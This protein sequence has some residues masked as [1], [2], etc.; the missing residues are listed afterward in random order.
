MLI[1]QDSRQ[2]KVY[3]EVFISKVRLGLAISRF[4]QFY[5]QRTISDPSSTGAINARHKP[6]RWSI[7]LG[8]ARLNWAFFEL[9]KLSRNFLDKLSSLNYKNSLFGSGNALY[10]LSFNPSSAQIIHLGWSKSGGLAMST[11]S[12]LQDLVF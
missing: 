5:S 10:I 11:L 4:D 1:G 8:Q 6:T 2:T 7:R 9:Y 3:V 12:L